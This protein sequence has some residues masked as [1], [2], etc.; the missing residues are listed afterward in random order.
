MWFNR[1]TIFEKTV[2]LSAELPQLTRRR[3]VWHMKS[4]IEAIEKIDRSIED[5]DLIVV[6][7]FTGDY[8]YPS[9]ALKLKQM[10]NLKDAECFDVM[11]N[12]TGFQTAIDVASTK[13]KLDPS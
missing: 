3:Q 5:I 9:T 1:G 2:L 6:A 13:M 11:A 12:C 10:L 7:T 8:T 4:R